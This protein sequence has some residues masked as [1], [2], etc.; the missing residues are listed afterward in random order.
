MS[1]YITVTLPNNEGT[2]LIKKSLVDFVRQS[3]EN[4]DGN[5]IIN[6][7]AHYIPVMEEY[8][9]VVSMLD[10]A[11][12]QLEPRRLTTEDIAKLALGDDDECEVMPHNLDAIIAKAK[13]CDELRTKII[14]PEGDDND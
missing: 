1:D 8:D 6:A 5:T 11:A 2:G 10:I 13:R 3:E 7:G 9:E 14:I 12:L 4:E